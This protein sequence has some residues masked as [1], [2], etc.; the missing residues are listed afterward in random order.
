MEE[1]LNVILAKLKAGVP[2]LRWA[3]INLGQMATENPPVD[4][5]CALVD[6]TDISYTTAGMRRQ[7]G[8]ARIE[9]ELYFI[10]RSPSNAAA[11]EDLR[12]QAFGHFTI[13]KKVYKALEGVSGEAFGGL[14][15]V[16][17]RRDKGY[18]PRSFTLV[19]RCSIEDQAAIPK[20]QK[21]PGV[22]PGILTESK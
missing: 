5:P 21:L 16:Q 10:V 2:E 11:P 19:F 6:V 7:V 4:Y 9:I 14:N 8:E 17:M 12:E 22:V 1:I 18:Y 15:R 3:D 13:V 20:F